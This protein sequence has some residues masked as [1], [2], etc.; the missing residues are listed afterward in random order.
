MDPEARTYKKSLESLTTAVMCHLALLDKVM[1]EPESP[2]RG[3]K[4]AQLCN[5]LDVANDQ[6]RYSVLGVDFRKDNKDKAYEK[7]LKS[8]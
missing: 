3:K 8:K 1:K 4:I 2:E 6:V 7:A 5:A